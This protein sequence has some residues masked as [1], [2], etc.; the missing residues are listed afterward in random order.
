MSFD[1]MVFD[2]AVAPTSAEAFAAW[3]RELTAWHEN[4]EFRL[5]PV[6]AGAAPKAWF[7]E[8]IRHFPPKDGPFSLPGWDQRRTWAAYRFAEP[9][10]WAQFRVEDTEMAASLGFEAARRHGLGV[11]DIGGDGRVWIPGPDGAHVAT[12]TVSRG[13]LA[14]IRDASK[15][16][17]LGGLFRRKG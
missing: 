16:G 5:D 12:M 4:D 3:Q 9:L 1:L 7:M 17:L 13:P 11:H 6:K 10:C 15:K 8:M 14:E 2:P